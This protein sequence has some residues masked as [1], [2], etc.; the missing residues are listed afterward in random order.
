[1]YRILKLRVKFINS[2]SYICRSPPPPKKIVDYNYYENH[3]QAKRIISVHA[4]TRYYM[5]FDFRENRVLQ[6]HE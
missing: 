2:Y 1:M 4:D 6:L 3:R 5:G